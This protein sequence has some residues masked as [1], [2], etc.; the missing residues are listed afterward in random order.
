MGPPTV[1]FSGS[2]PGFVTGP[3]EEVGVADNLPQEG[4]SASARHWGD[5]SD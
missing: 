3:F 1:N 4:V 5:G 2:V